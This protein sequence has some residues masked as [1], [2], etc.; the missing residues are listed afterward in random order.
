MVY[1]ELTW[2]KVDGVNHLL[3]YLRVSEVLVLVKKKKLFKQNNV[4]IH[5]IL[6]LKIQTW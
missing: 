3:K 6:F 5:T 2:I 1:I 4:Y